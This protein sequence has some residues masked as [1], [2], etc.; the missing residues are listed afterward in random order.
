MNHVHQVGFLWPDL[1]VFS[2]LHITSSHWTKL[3]GCI[4]N[5]L[6]MSTGSLT[7][8]AQGSA[9]KLTLFPRSHRTT[10]SWTK[11][12]KIDIKMKGVVL[13]QQLMCN[14]SWVISNMAAIRECSF[15]SISLK[16]YEIIMLIYNRKIYK[17]D[18]L[19]F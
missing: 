6:C 2:V 19:W 4:I 10:H 9:L 12:L 16:E 5:D 8:K 1:K 11:V 7:R 15:L 18:L 3:P 14:G 13:V 17:L